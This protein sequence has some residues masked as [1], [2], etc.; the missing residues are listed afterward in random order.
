MQHYFLSL[1]YHTRGNVNLQCCQDNAET[2]LR[3]Y[4]I[5]RFVVKTIT[6]SVNLGVEV[7]GKISN[8]ITNGMD[9]ST[10]INILYISGEL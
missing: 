8:R 5:I 4:F 9:R 2:G 10:Q 7:V 6:I 1:L 3:E